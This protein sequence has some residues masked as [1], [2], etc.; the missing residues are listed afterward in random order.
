[1]ECW[2][3]NSATPLKLL[4]QYGPEGKKS[5]KGMMMGPREPNSKSN[6]VLPRFGEVRSRITELQ[7]LI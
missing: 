2:P 7:L 5:D 4:L 6:P 1:M 3:G